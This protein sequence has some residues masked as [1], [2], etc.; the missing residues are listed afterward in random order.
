MKNVRL[1]ATEDGES[2]FENVETEFKSVDYAPPAP[3]LDMS[4]PVAAHRYVMV[5]FPAGWDSEL[6]P[7]PRRQ[8][9]VALSGEFDMEASDGS[10]MTF[11]AGDMCLMEDKTGK[12]HSARVR[13][14]K[15]VLGFAVHLE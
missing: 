7:T 5:R 14:D 1:F 15:D 10:V 11:A 4:E 6:H 13:G 3:A 2:H 8:H 12:G 9:F